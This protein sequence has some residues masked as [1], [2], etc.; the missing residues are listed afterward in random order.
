[1]AR[2]FCN[3]ALSPDN[4]DHL[5][6]ELTR[7]GDWEVVLPG[8]GFAGSNLVEGPSDP[9]LRDAVVAFGQPN[10]RDLLES[11]AL[12]FVQLTSAGWSRYDRADVRGR[13]TARKIALCTASHVYQEPCAEHVVA[14][15]FAQARQLTSAWRNQASERGWPV[16]VLRAGSRLLVGQRVVLLGYGTIARRVAELLGP[17]R[18][19]IVAFRRQVRGDE[20]VPTRPIAAV[21]EVLP[22][23]DHVINILPG[24]PETAHFVSAKR[25]AGFKQGSIYYNIGRGTTTDQDALLEALRSGHLAAA[26]L[27]VTDP[28]PLPATHPLWT[29]PNCFI[30]PHTAGGFIGEG[31]KQVEHLLGNLR[32][33]QAGE[34]LLDRVI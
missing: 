28:E 29:A 16:S 6:T 18:M 34:D 32:R 17:L 3:A 25:L 27:D 30:T 13:L 7:L 1:M 2:L 21:D 10:V 20:V 12:R 33:W 14:F 26:Y 11:E 8:N 4:L 9:A 5:R 15:L 23:A 31:R 19:E 22:T 24:T